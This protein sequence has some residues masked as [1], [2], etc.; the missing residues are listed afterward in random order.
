MASKKGDPTKKDFTGPR[1][2]GKKYR[3]AQATF[4]REK[5]HSLDE[6]ITLTKGT[7]TT[8]FDSSVEIHINMGLDVKQADQQLRGII[9]FPHGTGKK[10]SIVAFVDESKVKECKQ[11]GA[12]E[13]GTDTLM[14]KI[15][16]GWLDFD[17]AIA[18]PDQMKHIGK[19]AK[20][21]GQA[22][23][24]PNPKAGTVTPDPVK[25]IEEISK[26]QVEY[27][28]DKDANLHNLVGKVSFS[29]DQ[30]KENI[31]TYLKKISAAKPAGAKGTYINSITLTTSMG[32][33]IKVLVSEASSKL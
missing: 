8:K 10:V 9:S 25:T 6:A 2:H 20:T 14:E 27:R 33:G 12:I 28:T 7:A 1:L 5:L 32:P 18:T 16:G 30:L 15:N 11:A 19:I 13:A 4:E 21:L 22:G 29:E 23:K 17:I 3:T 26:G 24:M 31:K